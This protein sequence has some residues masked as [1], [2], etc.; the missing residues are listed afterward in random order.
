[1]Y[2]R[3]VATYGEPRISGARLSAMSVAISGFIAAMIG[4]SMRFVTFGRKVAGIGGNLSLPLENV[5]TGG[6]NAVVTGVL[7]GVAAVILAQFPY[8][9]WL[10]VVGL[11]TAGGLLWFSV[12]SLDRAYKRGPTGEGVL[13]LITN[14]RPA[15]G[16]WVMTCGA[17]AAAVGALIVLFARRLTGPTVVVIAGGTAQGLRG[18]SLPDR[19]RRAPKTS[20]RVPV[21]DRRPG[22]HPD[23]AG[24][25]QL[26][27]WDG[28]AWAPRPMTAETLAS[29]SLQR[30]TD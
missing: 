13:K 22:W 7:V 8:C 21:P 5:S 12:Y 19:S 10:A 29:P 25:R 3:H 23:P 24:T 11:V 6:K 15:T 26:R 9:R 16:F 27:W 2:C 30:I 28:T 4:S 18:A 20:G 17:G 1:M 14:P